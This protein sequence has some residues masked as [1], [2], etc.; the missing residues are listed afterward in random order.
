MLIPD[1]NGVYYYEDK[2]LQH[3]YAF[4][5]SFCRII[6]VFTTADGKKFVCENKWEDLNDIEKEICRQRGWNIDTVKDR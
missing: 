6:E 4:V 3:Y 5:D 2:R 1:R